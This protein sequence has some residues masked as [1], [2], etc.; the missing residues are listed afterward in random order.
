MIDVGV[1][2]VMRPRLIATT[3]LLAAGF[4]TQAYAANRVPTISGKPATAVNA[5]SAY[6]FR[7]TVADADGDTLTFSIVNRPAW[8]RFNTTTGQL[9]GTPTAASVGTYSNIYIV[10]GDGKTGAMLAPFSITVADVS[11]GSASLEWLPP[12]DNTDGSPLT[13][14]AGYRIVYG[15]SPRYLTHTIQVANAGV[16][17]YLVENLAPGTYYFAVRAYTSSGL[18]SANSNVLATVAQ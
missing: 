8:A 4:A 11:S 9:S 7:P 2:G 14:L 6:T 1:A 12:L 18:E 10:V 17:T 15:V 13:N 3:A 16:S 5:G